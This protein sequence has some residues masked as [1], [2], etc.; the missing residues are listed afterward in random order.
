M[1]KLIILRKIS[2]LFFLS[3]F[4]Y[5]LWSTT[6]PLQ[7]RL[8][9]DLFFKIDPSI[10]IFTSISERIFLPALL[11]SLLMLIFAVVFGRA[12]CGW[13]CPLGTMVDLSGAVRKN[14]NRLSEKANRV[15]SKTKYLIL[16]LITIGAIVGIQIAWILD[17]LVIMARFISLNFIP[18]ATLLTEKTF[19]FLVRDLGLYEGPVYDFYRALRESFLG[20]KTTYFSN[21]S[22]IFLVFLAVCAASVLVSRFWCRVLCPL[23]GMYGIFSR[24]SLLRRYVD[25]CVDCKKCVLNCRM[26]AIKNDIS[27][28]SSECVLCMD[29]VYDCPE[30]GVAFR[31]GKK[32]A[33][34]APV[35]TDE[36]GKVSR[37]DFLFL[38]L[39]SIFLFGFKKKTGAKETGKVIRPPGALEEDQFLNRC[40]RCSN[41]MKV[42]PTN[43]L[44]PEMMQ[45]G[46]G[47]IWTP[48]LVPEIGY[49]EYNCNLCGKVCPT[50]AIPELDVNVKKN[51][52]IGIAKVDRAKCIAWAHDSECL[53]CEEHCP[54]ASKAIKI[55]HTMVADKMIGRPVVD[56]QMCIG[57]GICQN[58]CPVRPVRA[59]RV[60]PGS[61]NRGKV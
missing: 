15:L 13:M 45:S 28:V 7:G 49:C 59:I 39:S 57:C 14:R 35:T 50:G 9:A 58:K 38:V 37:K 19:I 29:C 26:G 20:V 24:F 52:K 51:T 16:G 55:D 18:T 5:I 60:D 46:L 43:G 41:C 2:Q 40:I 34:K 36:K 25:K 42:C 61:A 31:I 33:E 3:L 32:V 23:G 8:P 21:A 47:G 6:Y 11:V 48:H 44:Q 53:V 30:Q 22:V 12:F 54:V 27:Y 1:K 56:E 17:P 4:V 10:M